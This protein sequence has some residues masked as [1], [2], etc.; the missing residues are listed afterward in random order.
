MIHQYL[1][2]IAF[3]IFSFCFLGL[4]PLSGTCQ[5]YHMEGQSNRIKS[6]NIHSPKSQ[7][8]SKPSFTPDSILLQLSTVGVPIEKDPSIRVC[9]PLSNLLLTSSFGW[10]RHPVT[11]KLDFH[12][13][14]D[15]SARSEPVYCILTGIVIE[16]GFN[17]LL[18]NFIRIDHGAVQSIYGHLSFIMVRQGQA[19]DV[20]KV[21]A[22]T[23]SS[24]RA[25]GEHLHFSIKTAGNYIHPLHFLHELTK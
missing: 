25:T 20:A 4:F 24:G 11:G 3:C 8:N 7:I 21:I 6:V 14:V 13:G 22:V 1:K 19:V 16:T 5:P 17:P 10:R 12:K 2:R 9:M 18:G 15:L 23:G